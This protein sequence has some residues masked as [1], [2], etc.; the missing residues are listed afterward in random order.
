MSGSRN[1]LSEQKE[2]S[3]RRAEDRG[4]LYSMHAPEVECIAKGKAHKRYEFGCKVSIVTTSKNGWVV[5]IDARHDNPYDGHTLRPA[6]AQVEKITAVKPE[7]VFAD[8]GFK[9]ADHHT[10]GV[11]V[12][13]SGSRRLSRTLKRLLRRRSAIEP[14]IGHM[15][16]EHG[17]ERNHL[18]GKEGDRI[19][20]MLTG[21][22]FNLRKLLRFFLGSSGDR[23]ALE[24]QQA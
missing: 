15:K 7:E 2:S 22:A 20:A 19:N 17:L 6:I 16:A 9:G 5:A 24:L 14:V 23:S 18:L 12:H 1:Y 10:E 21:C 8:Q 4:K 11:A 3:N 13:I